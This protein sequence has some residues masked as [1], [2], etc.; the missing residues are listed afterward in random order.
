MSGFNGDP[1]IYWNGGDG[2]DIVKQNGDYKRNPGIE[3]MINILL[4][5]KKNSWSNVFKAIPIPGFS[6]VAGE[7]ID[8]NAIRNIERDAET[9]LQP[10][11]DINVASDI[12]V[13]ASNPE[14]DKIILDISI[15]EKGGSTATYT[16]VWS[17][18]FD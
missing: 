14:A 4:G 15:T 1:Y 10:M 9:A 3:N 13:S 17:R 6:V 12:V 18:E 11:K 2:G 16:K 5:T 8:L 7:I